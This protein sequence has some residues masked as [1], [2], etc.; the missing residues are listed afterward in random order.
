MVCHQILPWALLLVASGPLW[1]HPITDSAERPYSGP[2]SVEDQ[3]VGSLDELS[4]SEQTFPL[5]DPAGLRY[6]SL[7]ASE[8]NR[9]AIRGTG[10]LP[11]G[12]KREVML[13]KQSLLNPFSRLLGIKK[14]FRKR[15]GNTECFWKYCV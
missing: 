9:E 14:Q 2:V 12:M 1:A 5:Q 8:L 10:L 13:E 3:G 6:A 7:L 11:R 4:L 15:G